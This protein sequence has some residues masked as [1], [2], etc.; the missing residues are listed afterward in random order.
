MNHRRRT[1]IFG[2][3]QGEQDTHGYPTMTSID[4]DEYHVKG[5]YPVQGKTGSRWIADRGGISLENQFSTPSEISIHS[6][7][8]TAQ[9]FRSDPSRS[10]QK[11]P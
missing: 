8:S 1:A 7:L 4:S 5:E 10:R 6:A 3:A 2:C 9:G 11:T